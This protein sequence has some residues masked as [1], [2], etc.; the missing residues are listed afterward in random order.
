MTL[1]DYLI[2]KCEAKELEIYFK[3]DGELPPYNSSF[4]NELKPLLERKYKQG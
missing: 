2:N 4:P 3:K 1:P